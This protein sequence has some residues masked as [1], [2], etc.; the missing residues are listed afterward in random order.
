MYAFIGSEMRTPAPASKYP[1]CLGG[2]RNDSPKI[3]SS[4]VAGPYWRWNAPE[5]SSRS[6][7]NS[8]GL[9]RPTKACSRESICG[10]GKLA[11]NRSMVRR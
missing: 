4:S 7:M 2:D 1:P 9:T 6:V 10:S 11:L 5:Y 3:V 8:S